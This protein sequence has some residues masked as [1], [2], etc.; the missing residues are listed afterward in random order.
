VSEGLHETRFT[1]FTTQ[2]IRAGRQRVGFRLEAFDGRSMILASVDNRSFHRV[3]KYGVDI[4][5]FDRLVDSVLGRE[6]VS[7]VYLIDEIGKMECLSSRFVAA[8]TTILESTAPVI[9]TIA[10]R[11]DG[12]IQRI[13]ERPDADLWQVTRA[14]RDDLPLRAIAWLKERRAV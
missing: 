8:V 7:A 10:A 4:A 6:N 9:A 3:G 2:E 11:G 1:G 13:K 14:N 12:F 5:A